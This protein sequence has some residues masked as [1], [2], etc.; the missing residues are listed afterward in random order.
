MQRV[1]KSRAPSDGIGW[2]LE[3]VAALVKYYPSFTL[4]YVM[5]ELPM[6]EGWCWWT[7]AILNDP[8]N[9]F[10]GAKVVDG[11]VKQM[12]D[13]LFEQAKTAWLK[14]LK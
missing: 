4:E 9:K 5:D 2:F 12:A 7:Y 1:N 13:E 11:Y 6:E 10:S 8:V 3:Y 14:E